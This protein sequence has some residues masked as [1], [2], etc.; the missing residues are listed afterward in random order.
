V[1]KQGVDGTKC[2][3]P[4]YWWVHSD[5]DLEWEEFGMYLG[6]PEYTS[7]YCNPGNEI[8]GWAPSFGADPVIDNIVSYGTLSD[9][10][11]RSQKPPPADPASSLVDTTCRISLA[12]LPDPNTGKMPASIQYPAPLHP[13]VYVVTRQF[14][15]WFISATQPEWPFRPYG[16]LV[17]LFWA[18]FTLFWLWTFFMNYACWITLLLPVLS[19]STCCGPRQCWRVV[20]RT[21][22]QPI[23]ELIDCW[24]CVETPGLGDDGGITV[25]QRLPCY[26]ECCCFCCICSDFN[27]NHKPCCGKIGLCAKFCSEDGHG[28]PGT[29]YVDK[30]G[31]TSNARLDYGH[32]YFRNRAADTFTNVPLPACFGGTSFDFP[33]ANIR[34]VLLVGPQLIGKRTILKFA[35]ARG[36]E[37]C[38]LGAE[39]APTPQV[40]WKNALAKFKA[41]REDP[42]RKSAA[43]VIF[44]A[45]GTA[46]EQHAMPAAEVVRLAQVEGVEVV[47]LLWEADAGEKTLASQSRTRRDSAQHLW[48]SDT[49]LAQGPG[50]G[51][52]GVALVKTLEPLSIHY[53][54]NCR[55]PAALTMCRWLQRVDQKNCN[56]DKLCAIKDRWVSASP[57][58]S[59]SAEDA[60]PWKRVFGRRIMV[61]MD[62]EEALVRILMPYRG[63]RTGP[64]ILWGGCTKG[65]P[66]LSGDPVDIREFPKAQGDPFASES[67]HPV[68]L[69]SRMV[70][71][72]HVAKSVK[73]NRRPS[74]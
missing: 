6:E 47:F 29:F 36:F 39:A 63:R 31:P 33:N 38:D 61:D 67:T 60:N 25:S 21:L 53:Q 66:S 51:G 44:G 72:S 20:Q 62:P 56:R 22:M 42:A 41:L 50:A 48:T 18:G 15:G 58:S 46:W 19:Y 9:P 7:S 8:P 74:F 13:T 2:Y 73:R 30:I 43:P 40:R 23:R 1:N 68:E 49:T 64:S 54:K 34:A 71:L 35:Q 59:M 32:D 70:K 3:T 55:A 69:S 45:G 24:L 11:T 52:A 65:A 5:F 4:N 12:P 28:T 10:F 26:G 37:T 16:T 57:K 27:P 14:G 17:G